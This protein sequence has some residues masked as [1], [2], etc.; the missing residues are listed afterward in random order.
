[1]RRIWKK[2]LSAVLCLLLTLC[3]VLGAVPLNGMEAQAADE[4]EFEIDENG[5]L[6][7]Y[8][9]SGGDVV[10]PEGVTGIGT[11][12][13][14]YSDITSVTIPESV[15]YIDTSAFEYCCSLTNITISDGVTT[16]DNMAFSN[17]SSLTNIFISKNVQYISHSAFVYCSGLEHIS[18]AAEN[19]TYNS[20]NNCNAIIE[21]STNK[22][23]LGCKNTIIPESVE[24]ID[25]Y[26]FFGRNNLTNI[27]IP[28]NVSLIHTYS[29][30]LCRNLTS[31]SIPKNVTYIGARAF[32]SCS[33]LEH[34]SVAAENETYHS[35][36]NC[37]A[38]IETKTNALIRGCKN[39]RIPENVSAI[40]DYAFYGCNS[41]TSIIIPKSVT[42]IGDDA[43]YECSE[44]LTIYGTAGSYAETYA[45]ENDIKFSTGEVPQPQPQPEQPQP[46]PAEPK[47]L[48]ANNVTL[49]QT[50]YAYDGKA[51]KPTV[52]VRDGNTLLT[53]GTDYTVAYQN[54]KNAGMARAIITGKGN[55]KGTVTKTFTIAVKKNTSHKV[56]SFQYKVTGTSAASLTAI[57]SSKV[58]KVKVPKTVKIGGKTF[59]VTAIG[60]NAFKKNKKITTVEISD[61]VKTVGTGAFESC[62][63]LSK[64]TVGKNVTEIGKNAFKNCKKLGNITIK[65]T[66][67]KKVGANALRGIKSNAKIKVPAKKLSAYQKLFKN[68]GQGK[69]VKIVR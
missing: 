24:C 5:V 54:N 58:T 39:T 48:S 15:S 53:A 4:K 45:K 30:A 34:I 33:G 55:Y 60:S 44:E 3:T 17:C 67:L 51:K 69:K 59:K 20:N 41:L 23:V 32:S 28:E 19:K 31:I 25:V 12:A 50:S 11:N 22:L 13:F 64:V 7:K 18:V 37:N 38:I 52:T 9:G 43:F 10:I 21:T 16:I 27:T 14:K 36:N 8:N 6:T 35:N 1:M 42:S 61:N 2:K 49:S 29:F 46:Q 66:K 56:G 57:K 65:S 40:C 47:T 26:A 63:K 68:K 62:A